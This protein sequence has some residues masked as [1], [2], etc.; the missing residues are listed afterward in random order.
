MLNLRQHLFWSRASDW[1]LNQNFENLLVVIITV[2]ILIQ[3]AKYWTLSQKK[4]LIGISFEVKSF[5]TQIR[6]VTLNK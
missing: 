1:W 3:K 4:A 5:D 2:N 6:E